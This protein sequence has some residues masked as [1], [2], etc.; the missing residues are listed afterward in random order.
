MSIGLLLSRAA[1]E[2]FGARIH[3]L[4]AGREHRIVTL[5]EADP[6][7]TP[8]DIA[9]LS[10]DITGKSSKLQL[11]ETMQR[12]FDTL[13]AAER[14]QWL[15]VHSAGTDRPVYPPLF[16]RG[17]TITNSSGAS[18]KTIGVSVLG[19]M[20]ALARGFVAQW[21]AQRRHAWEPLPEVDGP[22]EFGAGTAVVVG[23]GPIGR[24]ISRLLRAFGL[25]VVGVR[26]S[27]SA[28]GDG[29]GEGGS[30]SPLGEGR[31]E[32][33]LVAECDE[34]VAYGDLPRVLPR[35]GWLVLACPLT[36]VTRGLVDA[37]ALALLPAGARIVNVARGE[38]VDE[39]A[40]TRALQDGRLGGAWLDVFHH[41]PL[42]PASPLW[43]LPNV[44]VSPHSSSRSNGHYDFVGEIFLDNLARW[45]DGRPLRNVSLNAP[46]S[47][48]A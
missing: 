24:E 31:G 33:W 15:H 3:D 28:S 6:R 22:P 37:K 4:L 11:V 10:R 46:A 36:E 19:G 23:L 35:A 21:Q 12:F 48:G 44:I 26:R 40:M 27:P 18:A 32:G 7:A 14:L 47:E 39:A 5:E 2:R 25:T 30:P 38:V 45:R 1:A 13:G 41:E 42:D 16:A 8:I 17:V 20:I 34:T 9:L 29:R 43:D